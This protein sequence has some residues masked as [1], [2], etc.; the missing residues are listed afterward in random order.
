[1]DAAL[2][3]LLKQTSRSFYLSI[4][5]LPAAIRPQ[6]G[7]AYLLARATDTVADTGGLPVVL[8]REALC[9]MQAAIAAAAEGRALPAPRLEAPAAMLGPAEK[10]LLRS[11]GTILASVLRLPDADRSQIGRVLATIT[12]GQALD[13]ARFGNAG[14]QSMAALSTDEELDDYIQ[15]V[16]GCVGEFWTRICRSHLFPDAPLD[17]AALLSN[18]VRFGKGLQLVNILRDLPRD[19]RQGRCYIPR[20]L[21][22][23]RGLS[24]EDLLDHA[25]M[26]PFRLLYEDYLDKAGVQLEAGRAYIMALPR[27]HVRVRLACL[28]PLMIGRKTI[29]LL[30]AGNVLN[31]NLSIKV[32]R[33]DLTWIMLSSLRHL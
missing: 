3:R 18:G 8:R 31:S 1:M 21:L 11:F 27:R 6:I 32:S 24:P 25:A 7:L 4:R 15:R 23:G 2:Q 28:W 13:L 17:E 29:E 33:S 9:R 20:V 16:A 19:L 14:G 22:E 10:Q 12:S 30:R 26:D 5:I